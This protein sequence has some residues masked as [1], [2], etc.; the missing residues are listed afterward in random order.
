MTDRLSIDCRA[1]HRVGARGT[2]GPPGRPC[3]LSSR[4]NRAPWDALRPH[5]AHERAAP[6][7]SS[8]LPG[9]YADFTFFV[10]SAGE[11]S[12]RRPRP[13]ERPSPAC[14][15]TGLIRPGTGDHPDRE[16][17]AFSG[18][19]LM[20]RRCRDRHARS[21]DSRTGV[22]C[23]ASPAVCPATR[24]PGQPNGTSGR[25]PRTTASARRS[26]APG[27]SQEGQQHR[28]A[29]L[30]DR[31]RRPD[32]R[33]RRCRGRL[34]AAAHAPGRHQRRPRA[35]ETRDRG[36]SPDHRAVRPSLTFRSP[37]P[38]PGAAPPTEGG[39]K[40]VVELES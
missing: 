38:G 13:A 2:A 28:S 5:R 6:A 22:H 7:M 17:R 20:V 18:R 30:H 16:N 12:E 37:G 4:R 14:A 3:S 21:H 32:R 27:A 29:A 36:S 9:V 1:I 24:S 33:C 10:G 26:A 8:L 31:P 40:I 39:Q 19:C 35:V 34:S 11:S 25:R 23:T 15:S